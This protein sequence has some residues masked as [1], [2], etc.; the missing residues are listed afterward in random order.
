MAAGDVTEK[1]TDKYKDTMDNLGPAKWAVDPLGSLASEFGLTGSTQRNVDITPWSRGEEANNIFG[2]ISDR[3]GQWEQNALDREN[4]FG[5]L[6]DNARGMQGSYLQMGDQADQRYAS[7]WENQD[8]ADQDAWARSDQEGA[9]QLAREAAMGMAPSVAENQMYAGLDQAAAQQQSQAAGARGLAALSTA[10][11]NAQANTANMQNQVFN[12]AAQLRAGEMAD[13]RGMYGSLSGQMRG[14]DQN[15]MQMG[16][17][18]S[19]FNAGA[20]NQYAQNQYGQANQAGQ[21]GV[22]YGQLENQAGQTGAQS[23]AQ[24]GQT[25][26]E[27]SRL[28]SAEEDKFLDRT[29]G[30]ANQNTAQENA[31]KKKAFDLVQGGGKT[32]MNMNGVPV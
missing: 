31:D 21:Q 22:A 26:M 25:G 6:G 14:A 9:T 18:M 16:N 20:R 17:Q 1:R 32:L 3:Q 19:Q 7:A 2:G 23:A 10:Q 30:T 13:A 5:Q 29:L 15:R 28:R 8:L 24:H 12:Q 27:Q 4:K 11:T